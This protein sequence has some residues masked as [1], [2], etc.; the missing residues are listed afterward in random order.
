MS[1][2]QI[3]AGIRLNIGGREIDLTLEEARQLQLTLSDILGNNVREHHHHIHYERVIPQPVRV[4][5]WTWP[6]L[7]APTTIGDVS[8]NRTYVLSDGN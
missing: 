6:Y 3:I 5:E 4:R 2:T 8:D 1:S 7:T